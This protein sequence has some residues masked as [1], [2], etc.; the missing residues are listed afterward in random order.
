MDSWFDDNFFKEKWEELGGSLLREGEREVWGLSG[1]LKGLLGLLGLKGRQGETEERK[2]ETEERKGEGEFEKRRVEKKREKWSCDERE[3][4]DKMEE[5]KEWEERDKSEVLE[6][7]LER[8]GGVK[9]EEE[10]VGENEGE[11]DGE[12]DSKSETRSESESGVY[13]RSWRRSGRFGPG[14][15]CEV[16][17]E[18]SDSRSGGKREQG[19]LRVLGGQWVGRRREVDGKGVIL[20]EQEE[21]GGGLKEDEVEEFVG[22]WSSAGGRKWPSLWGRGWNRGRAAL[23]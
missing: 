21:R 15:Y 22:R 13:W 19:E 12:G 7:E 1:G 9:V 4:W 10:G 8:V 20:G 18:K 11:S 17:E 14:G 16:K 5:G 6:E 23:R 2:G 3:K